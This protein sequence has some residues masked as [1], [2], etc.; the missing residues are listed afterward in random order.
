VR[1]AVAAIGAHGAL[2]FIPKERSA[3]WRDRPAVAAPLLRSIVPFMC[4]KNERVNKI[5]APSG[6]AGARI[7][8]AGD[9]A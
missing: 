5:S 1:S 8:R 9:S 4:T 3:D 6:L 2:Y 7:E